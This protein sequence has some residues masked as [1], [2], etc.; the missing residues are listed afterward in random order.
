M[1]KEQLRLRLLSEDP[2]EA[3]LLSNMLEEEMEEDNEQQELT[4]K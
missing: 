1:T 3:Q 2:E 4:S